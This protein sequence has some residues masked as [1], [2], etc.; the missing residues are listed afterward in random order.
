MP[1]QISVSGQITGVPAGTIT[2]GPFTIPTNDTSNASIISIVLASG[3]NT[4]GIPPWT[5]GVIIVP[6]TNNTEALILKG[7]TGD[8]GVDI[9]PNQPSVIPFPTS[10]LSP[11]LVISAADDTTNHTDFIFF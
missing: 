10:G 9:S 8:T 2:P 5:V 4:I 3:D 11:H 1:G 6:P 7:D